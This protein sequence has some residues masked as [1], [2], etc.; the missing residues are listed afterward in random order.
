MI[1]FYHI[2]YLFTGKKKT[3]NHLVTINLTLNNYLLSSLQKMQSFVFWT[4]YQIYSTQI[5]KTYFIACL[6]YSIC[7]FYL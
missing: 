1:F 3:L 4:E 6:L 2:F 7:T 5:I